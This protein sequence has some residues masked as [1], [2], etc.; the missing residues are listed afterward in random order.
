[1]VTGCV[2]LATDDE[3]AQAKTFV[4]AP[5]KASIYLYRDVFFGGGVIATVNLD[6][7]PA[8]AM[9]GKTFFLWV[10]EPGPHVIDVTNEN[11]LVGNHDLVAG[12]TH[13]T[14]EAGKN[15]YIWHEIDFGGSRLYRVDE[16]IGRHGVLRCNRLE[17]TF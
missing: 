13:L 1:M 10:V 14:V 17:Q 9:R 15:Y 16:K 11:P 5:D 2:S 8:G 6:G 12:A 7:R 4:V 3:D